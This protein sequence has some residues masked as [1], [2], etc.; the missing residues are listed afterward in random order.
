[1]VKSD[2]VRSLTSAVPMSMIRY[3]ARALGWIEQ[4]VPVLPRADPLV[5]TYDL[6]GEVVVD[7]LMTVGPLCHHFKLGPHSVPAGLILYWA[8]FTYHIGYIWEA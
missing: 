3:I 2:G 5:I 6:R 7:T 8:A 1:M 4:V